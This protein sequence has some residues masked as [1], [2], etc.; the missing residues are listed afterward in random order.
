MAPIPRPIADRF[1]EKVEIGA[2]DECWPWT[3][4]LR[5]GYGA[6]MI[7][8]TKRHKSA[9]RISYEMHHGPIPPGMCVMHSCDNRACV[10]PAHLSIGTRGDNNTDR[11]IKGRDRKKTPGVPGRY[12]RK[13]AA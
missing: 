5:M 3:A 8:A 2:G 13:L 9:H 7:A 6:L 10:N 1:W 4:C 12:R 11:H